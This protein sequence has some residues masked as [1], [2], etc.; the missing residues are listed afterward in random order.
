MSKDETIQLTKKIGS[1]YVLDVFHNVSK[2]ETANFFK[3]SVLNNKKGIIIT[4]ELYKLREN[5]VLDKIGK[6]I[7]GRWNLIES[8]W[9]N[10]TPN[11]IIEYPDKDK[12]FF[13]TREQNN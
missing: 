8:S 2:V 5:K 7:E 1:K 4:D 10:K 12:M 3:K 6:E 9:E 13:Y 11:M